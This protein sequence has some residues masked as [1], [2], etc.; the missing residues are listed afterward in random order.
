MLFSEEIHDRTGTG[1][2]T[3]SV[4][5]QSDD[6]VQRPKPSLKLLQFPRVR[7]MWCCTSFALLYMLAV[8]HLYSASSFNAFLFHVNLVFDWH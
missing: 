6:A 2:C 3:T 4:D 5:Y 1:I 7:F 8:V